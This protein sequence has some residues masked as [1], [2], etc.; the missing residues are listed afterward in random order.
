MHLG[1]TQVVDLVAI[2]PPFSNVYKSPLVVEYHLMRCN[3]IFM[4]NLVAQTRILS[5]KHQ[6]VADYGRY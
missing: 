2:K 1:N 3:L 5:L 6:F 4:V